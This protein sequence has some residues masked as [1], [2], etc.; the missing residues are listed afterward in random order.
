LRKIS[1]IMNQVHISPD[2]IQGV[3]IGAAKMDSGLLN[4]VSPPI[5]LGMGV[6]QGFAFAKSGAHEPDL[7]RKQMRLEDYTMAKTFFAAGLAETGV[8]TALSA[9]G[10]VSILTI[11][12]SLL[13]QAIGGALLG[14]GM[15]LSG[16]SP[17]AVF[18]QLGS[19]KKESYFA[20]AGGLLGA[21]SYG[22]LQR[23]IT[24]W[25]AGVL[26]TNLVA[27]ETNQAISEQLVSN[28]YMGLPPWAISIPVCAALAG[29]LFLMEALQPTEIKT[30]KESDNLSFFEKLLRQKR[31]SPYLCGAIIGLLQ[32]PAFFLWKSPASPSSVFS[33]AAGYVAK[34]MG[35]T[36]FYFQPEMI[37]NRPIWRM[38]L[39]LGIIGGSYLALNSY[40]SQKKKDEMAMTKE[41]LPEPISYKNMA[42]SAAGGAMM[43]FGSRM[44]NRFSPMTVASMFASG[45]ITASIIPAKIFDV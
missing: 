33:T 11:P 40:W 34:L 5:S 17:E 43:V 36:P 27:P 26:K 4:Q 21:L 19:K 29:G 39:G 37:G 31:W 44:A 9:T 13:H 12:Q 14:G 15:Y 20:A 10:L 32:I 3:L 41:P 6:L 25:L 24:D 45:F 23:R 28:Q 42:L 1:Q 22:F 7:I 38:L 18:V 35:K 30:H 16:S 8:L 2:A